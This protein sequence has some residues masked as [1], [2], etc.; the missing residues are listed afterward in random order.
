MR[1]Q[2]LKTN[3]IFNLI[4]VIS[5]LLFPLITFPYVSRV[6]MPNGIGQVQFFQSI[7]NYIILFTSIGIPTYAIREVAKVRDNK[8][9]MSKTSVEILLLHFILT[10]IGYFIVGIISITYSKVQEDLWL[11]FI[12]SG[13]IAFTAIGCNWFYSGIEEFKYITIRGLIVKIVCVILLFIFVKTKYDL[14]FYAIYCVLGTV[15]NNVINFVRL[16]KY[17]DL[18]SFRIKELQL[19]RHLKPAMHVFVLNLVVSIYVNLDTVMLGVLSDAASVGYYTAATRLSHM[20]V[21]L[22]ISLGTVLL[23]RLS[24]LIKNSQY[25]EFKRLSQKSY[26]F[27][28]CMSLP[29]TFGVI[30]ISRPLLLLFSGEAFIPAVSTLRLMIPITIIIGLSNLIGMQILYPQD[31]INL[32]IVCTSIGAAI[33]FVM[34]LCLIPI[35][36]QDGAAI[37]TLTAEIAVSLS[38]FVLGRKYLPFDVINIDVIK[39]IVAT[40]I[41]FAV[42]FVIRQFVDNIFVELT[43]IIISCFI[44]YFTTLLVF[45]ASLAI[46]ILS[47]VRKKVK[48]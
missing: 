2:S 32:V 48:I 14:V 44:I 12:L 33:N 3:F 26:N 24:N 41:M 36:Q 6:I 30:L 40:T 7:I 4:N 25:D 28:L 39:Y 29:L 42:G 15:G 27:I 38:M 13:S 47:V 22:V 31:K 1:T 8:K 43:L 19:F 9:E 34:N 16:G 17:I 21:T 23:P 20:L 10:I 35:L 37:S 18:F 11:F 5:S 46:D 45:K